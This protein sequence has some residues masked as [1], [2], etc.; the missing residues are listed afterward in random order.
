[1]TPSRVTPPRAFRVQRGCLLGLSSAALAVAAHGMA[2]GG[3][4][5]TA[6]TVVLTVLVGWAGT[7]V[8]DRRH[9]TWSMLTLLGVSQL[10][11]HV[12]LTDIA[13]THPGHGAGAAVD[14]DLMLVTHVL[15]TVL[16]AVLLTKASVALGVLASALT[17]LVR[18]L[19]WTPVPVATTPRPAPVEVFRGHLLAVVFRQVCGR[20]GPPLGS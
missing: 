12:L 13:S 4:P 11:L 10:S 14:G 19:V 17:G 6:V 16:T 20:R 18:A 2:G 9:D 7:A 1:M 8:A 15:A 5:D 3:V